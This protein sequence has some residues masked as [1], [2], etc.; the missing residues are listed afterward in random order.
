MIDIDSAYPVSRNDNRLFDEF[1][2]SRDK[3]IVLYVGNFGKLK[4]EIILDV[5]SNNSDPTPLNEQNRFKMFLFTL[6]FKRICEDIVWGML[7][8]SLVKKEL[9]PVECRVKH[10]ASWH[11]IHR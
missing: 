2:I 4:V 6:F 11:A 8:L 9:E 3:Y 10:G 5:A 1:G 7:Q